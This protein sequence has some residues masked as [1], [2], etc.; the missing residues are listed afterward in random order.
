MNDDAAPTEPGP[1]RKRIEVMRFISIP[2]LGA[3]LFSS[4]S[5]AAVSSS[6]LC[7][8]KGKHE[9]CLLSFGDL[10]GAREQYSGKLVRINGY[11]VSGRGRLVL[12][13]GRDFFVFQQAV[14][15]IAIEVDQG[16][17][18]AARGRMKTLEGVRD[19]E[20]AS[21]CPVTVLGT[22]YAKP[23]G[24]FA[25]LGTLVSEGTGLM[26]S[27]VDAPCSLPEAVTPLP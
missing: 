9:I 25:T 13:P 4:G 21:S 3:L 23:S 1:A 19:W 2:L 8:G 18:H 11:L 14:G 16:T 27:S 6:P 12:Y 24:D 7:A 17:F 22:Y 15:G 10:W 5:S 26:V 20:Y